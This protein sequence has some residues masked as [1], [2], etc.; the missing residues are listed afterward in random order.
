MRNLLYRL[1]WYRRR[2]ARR[3][4]ERHEFSLEGAERAK[5][6]ITEYGDVADVTPSQMDILHEAIDRAEA[7]IRRQDAQ[8]EAMESL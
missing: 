2:I 4:E 5:R 1:K 6:A 7:A 3:E 8:N